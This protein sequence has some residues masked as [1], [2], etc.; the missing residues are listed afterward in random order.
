MFNAINEAIRT[1]VTR[2]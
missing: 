1:P 2:V